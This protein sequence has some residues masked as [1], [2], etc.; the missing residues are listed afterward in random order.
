[1]TSSDLTGLAVIVERGKAN[2]VVDAAKEAG[3]MGA[4][5]LQGRGTA[6]EEILKLFT[7]RV[8]SLK[9]IVLIIG[10]NDSLEKV[11]E[12]IAEKIKLREPGRGIAF[13][14]PINKIVGLEYKSQTQA[15]K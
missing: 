9:E 1:M 8:N 7:I 14:F 11:L 6:T 10:E 2:H 15:E 4:T 3:A 12:H 5:V 13:T